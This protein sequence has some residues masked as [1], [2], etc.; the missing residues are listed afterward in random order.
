[1]TPD[2]RQHQHNRIIDICR[3]NI[4]MLRRRL[5]EWEPCYHP[6]LQRE[7][8]QNMHV[9][10]KEIEDYRNDWRLFDVDDRPSP[11]TIIEIKCPA[12]SYGWGPARFFEWS[13]ILIKWWRPKR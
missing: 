5:R 10:K 1:M 8:E 3:S 7:I 4:A 12:G 13:E 2:E 6:D 9:M 11:D